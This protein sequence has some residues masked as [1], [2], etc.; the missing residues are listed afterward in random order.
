MPNYCQAGDIARVTFPD[1]VVR[2]YTDTPILVTC[3]PLP[4]EYRVEWDLG[5]TY[6]P[7]GQTGYERSVERRWSRGGIFPF[8]TVC[9]NN[10]LF[11]QFFDNGVTGTPNVPKAD[12]YWS[13]NTRYGYYYK[14]VCSV[15]SMFAVMISVSPWVPGSVPQNQL[16]IIGLSG[17]QLFLGN[18]PNCNFSVE[19]VKSCPPNTLDCGDCC[20]DCMSIFNGISSIRKIIAGLK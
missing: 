11:S 2:E 7:N 12:A 10:Q 13:N 14:N 15:W 9:I 5:V 18:F 17:T 8:R 4:H 3:E 16:K 6:T 20:L 19:C 1:R